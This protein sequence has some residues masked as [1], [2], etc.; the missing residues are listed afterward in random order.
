MSLKVSKALITEGV[1]SMS[2]TTVAKTEQNLQKAQAP[3][4]KLL[5]GPSQMTQIFRAQLPLPGNEV[6]F[7]LLIQLLVLGK[8][9]RETFRLEGSLR[10]C[11]S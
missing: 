7:L 3:S 5:Q 1:H 9:Q 8:A 4:S 2:K 6:A 11:D 10:R